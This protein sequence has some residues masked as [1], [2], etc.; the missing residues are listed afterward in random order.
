[1]RAAKLP[2]RLA[3]SPSGGS[4]PGAQTGAPRNSLGT[5]PCASVFAPE[6]P[7]SPATVPLL[8]EPAVTPHHYF[9]QGGRTLTNT[10]RLRSRRAFPFGFLTYCAEIVHVVRILDQPLVQIVTDSFA[11][12]TDKIDPLDRLIDALTIEYTPFKLFDTDP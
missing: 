4:P 8:A 2:R 10:A 3:P 6:R 7:S 11:R 5:T 1:G 12:R 9:W